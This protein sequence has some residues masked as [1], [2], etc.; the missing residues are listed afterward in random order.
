MMAEL[1]RSRSS[2][3]FLDR[4]CL[5][6]PAA[7]SWSP[8]AHGVEATPPDQPPAEGVR[9]VRFASRRASLRYPDEVHENLPIQTLGI[10]GQITGR[11][12]GRK[13][14]MFPDREGREA[15]VLGRVFLDTD[16]GPAAIEGD[17]NVL[18][19]VRAL[20]LADGDVITIARP[21]KDVYHVV[22]H[23]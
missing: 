22:R 1:T 12:R 8:R 14:H 10:S 6:L 15:G 13:F 19:Q 7:C 23:R 4:G 9:G 3:M 11:Y 18:Q 2:H 5:P 16:E 17:E 20:D 21:S